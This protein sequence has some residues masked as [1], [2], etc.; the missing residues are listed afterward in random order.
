MKHVYAIYFSPAQSTKL[1][2][3]HITLNIGYLTVPTTHI[4]I[5]YSKDREK[6][7]EFGQD[8]LVIFAFPTYGGRAPNVMPSIFDNVR[9]KKTPLVLVASYGDIDYDDSLLEACKRLTENGF[10]CAA[11]LSVPTQHTIAPKVGA[12]RPST[13]DFDKLKEYS[14][15]IRQ[16]LD[17]AD[18]YGEDLILP[19]SYPHKDYVGGPKIAPET[20]DECIK[21]MLCYQWCPVDAIPHYHPKDTDPNKCIKCQGCV[22]RCPVKARAFK[23]PGFLEKA[24]Q[25]EEKNFNNNHEIQLFL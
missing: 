22:I 7:Y 14:L 1:L 25:T 12:G 19:G 3:Q 17:M 10:V 11:A 16:K 21:C 24:K 5:T 6:L 4:N 15:V 13:S 2:A 18:F 9:G 23:H 20:S 8:D